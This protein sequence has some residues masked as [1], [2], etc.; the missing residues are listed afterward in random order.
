MI[1]YIV[2][3]EK[4]TVVAMI[5]F[6]KKQETFKDSDWVLYRLAEAFSCLKHND[7]EATK[8][9]RDLEEKMFFPKVMSAK[10]KC[11]PE[12]EWDEEYGKDLARARLVEKIKNYR[13]NSYKIVGDLVTKIYDTIYVV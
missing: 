7:Y 13:S 6:D 11:A 1:E 12:D 3:K 5:K 8:A 10:A 9:Y 2:N 4:R